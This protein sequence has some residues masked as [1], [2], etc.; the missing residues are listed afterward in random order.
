MFTYPGLNCGKTYGRR[1]YETGG[2]NTRRERMMKDKGMK[3]VIVAD[4]MAIIVVG[5]LLW[6][7]YIDREV[8]RQQLE[9]QA[10]TQL[11]Q[12]KPAPKSYDFDLL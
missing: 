7:S 2:R 5:L 1:R 12:D 11:G 4:V 10:E 9:A 8:E 3:W 6:A